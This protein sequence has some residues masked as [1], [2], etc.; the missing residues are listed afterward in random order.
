MSTG[1]AE[2]DKNW[3]C[4]D[5]RGN[6]KIYDFI[7]ASKINAIPIPEVSLSRLNKDSKNSININDNYYKFNNNKP[8]S[9]I[10]VQKYIKLKDKY[11]NPLK[12]IGNASRNNEVATSYG[13]AFM[14]VVFNNDTIKFKTNAYMSN[15]GLSTYLNIYALDTTNISKNSFLLLNIDDNSKDN[16]LYILMSK[17]N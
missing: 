1:V 3:I 7:D 17:K 2:K 8:Y 5:E 4:F 14:S 9:N 16:G 15:M 12:G 11:Q 6:F 13:I 10:Y